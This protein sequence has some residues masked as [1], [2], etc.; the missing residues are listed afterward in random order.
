MCAGNSYCRDFK[1]HCPSQFVEF[2]KQCVNQSL[3]ALPNNITNK[4][5][6]NYCVRNEECFDGFLC[7]E[8]RCDCAPEKMRYKSKCVPNYPIDNT[9]E[10][11]DNEERYK[12][13]HLIKANGIDQIFSTMAMLKNTPNNINSYEKLPSLKKLHQ[14]GLDQPTSI[15]IGDLLNLTKREVLKSYNETCS[16][17]E[18]C[19]S[20][21]K[22]IKGLCICDYGYSFKVFI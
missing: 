16:S 3:N 21:T 2:E 11:L 6:S 10:N 1:C 19:I 12:N 20:N 8:N 17:T 9:L 4:S 14:S 7:L 18:T 15:E 13:T 5:F 22:C